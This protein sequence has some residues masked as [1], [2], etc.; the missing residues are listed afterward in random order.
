MKLGEI[1]THTDEEKAKGTA[2]L[3]ENLAV[4]SKIITSIV[5]LRIKL[6]DKLIKTA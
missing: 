4:M 6:K 2:F 3:Q 5:Y 1:G